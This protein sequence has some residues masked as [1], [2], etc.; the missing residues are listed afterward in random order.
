MPGR[1]VWGRR[2]TVAILSIASV[3][4]VSTGDAAAQE[5]SV[6]SLRLVPGGTASRH[7][8]EE[9]YRPSIL[10]RMQEVMGPLPSHDRTR[11]L[12][13]KLLEE[14]DGGEYWRQLLTYEPEPG[15]T[16]PLYV[17]IPKRV[18]YGNLKTYGVLCLHQTRAEGHK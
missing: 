6:N 18:L 12:N 9:I 14:V 10:G 11:P 7:E 15:S 3:L 4:F 5:R 2:R 8:W 13:V 17:L 1:H 16:V